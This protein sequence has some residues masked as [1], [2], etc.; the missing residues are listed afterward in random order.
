M[1]LC[2]QFVAG[3][4]GAQAC[5]LFCVCVSGGGG[6]YSVKMLLLAGGHFILHEQSLPTS[7]IL[8]GLVFNTLFLFLRTPLTYFI[9]SKLKALIPSRN[10]SCLIVFHAKVLDK[11]HLMLTNERVVAVLTKP[12]K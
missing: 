6:E 10:A 3:I 1:V 7:L 4:L 2:C 8:R 5:M 11:D 12:S 9:V